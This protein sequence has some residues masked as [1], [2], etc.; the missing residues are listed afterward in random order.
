M[1][2]KKDKWKRFLSVY[3]SVTGG[4]ECR[5]PAVD[6]VQT[7]RFLVLLNF[8]K[9]TETLIGLKCI[10]EYNARTSLEGATT[11]RKIH[12]MLQETS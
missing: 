1:L 5:R 10:C 8:Q 11:Q 7:N 6:N 9:L 3:H 12:V 4:G 2:Y